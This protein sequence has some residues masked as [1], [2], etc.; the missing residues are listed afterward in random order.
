MR[1]LL[2]FSSLLLFSCNKKDNEQFTP[3]VNDLRS[4]IKYKQINGIEPTL[5]SLD[6][7][8]NSDLDTQK[9]VIIYVHG[10]GWF[11]G[12]KRN[13]IENKVSLF[14]SLNYILV[15]VNYR[16]SPFPY[17]LNNS[18]RIMYPTHN[19]DIADAIKWIYNN[20]NQYGGNPNKIALLGHSAGAHLVSLIGT[21]SSFL[22]NVGLNL[23]HIKGVATI[24]TEGYDVLLKVQNNSNLYI[25]AFGT[26]TNKNLHASPIYNIKNGISYPIFFVAKRGNVQRITIANDFIN[27]LQDNGVT[28]SSID[29]SLYDHKGINN[30][31]GEPNETLITNPLKNFFVACFE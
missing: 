6:I 4:T 2:L 24:D 15:S 26:D 8:H 10:G 13:E 1:L 12:D 31:I 11:I 9:P 21:N 18:N 28:V 25:N 22:E 5:L 23:S 7:Y 19:N 16:L 27:S 20:I 3:T 14:Q 17:E 30:A 29:G